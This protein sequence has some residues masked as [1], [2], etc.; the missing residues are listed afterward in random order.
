M[1]AKAVGI[2]EGVRP[3]VLDATAGM[4]ADAFVMASLGCQVQLLERSPIVYEL[5][6]S[7]IQQGLLEAEHET[8]EAL[9][10]MRLVSG[11]SLEWLKRQEPEFV[12]VVYLDPMFPSRE[13]SA[14]VKK[15]MQ[16]FHQVVGPDEDADRL[17]SLAR[18]KAEYRVVVKRGLRSAYLDGI[19]PTYQL[20]GK[21]S[22]YDVYVNK[23]LKHHAG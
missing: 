1:I 3:T 20:K 8:S 19:E 2:G 6:R 16:F 10:R 7:G 17:L 11:D 14:L 22:R 21:S 4:G 12:D 5:L 13:K 15:E 23:S 18:S 9:G